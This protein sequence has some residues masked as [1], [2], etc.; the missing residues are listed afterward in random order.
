MFTKSQVKFIIFIFAIIIF[1]PLFGF[2]F[3]RVTGFVTSFQ[4]GADP[5]S[6][7]RG[8]TLIV[9]EPE[10]AV[11]LPFAEDEGNPPTLAQS[12]EIIAAYYDGWEAVSRSYFTRDTTDLLTYWGGAAYESV[13]ADITNPAITSQR[14]IGH[15]LELGFFSIDDSV[16]GFTDKRFWLTREIGGIEI[17]VQATAEVIMTNDNGWWRIRSLTIFYHEENTADMPFKFG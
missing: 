13:L 2:T 16:I 17:E 4:Q 12:E 7:F 14:H 1:V 3:S 6:I 9:P 15:H 8:H 5:A 11:W 10:Q